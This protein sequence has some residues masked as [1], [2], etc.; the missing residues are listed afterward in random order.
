MTLPTPMAVLKSPRP[1]E[2]SNLSSD[3]PVGKAKHNT[4]LNV[5]L[6]TEILC[7]PLRLVIEVSSVL[8]RY[9]VSFLG[10]IRA[11][12]LLQYLSSDAHDEIVLVLDFFVTLRGWMRLIW[13]L[14][15]VGREK[16]GKV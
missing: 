11:I 3:E 8:D 7:F 14:G 2:E 15:D 5:L 4:T 13:R 12:A 16:G 1:L 6:A 10:E 9:L